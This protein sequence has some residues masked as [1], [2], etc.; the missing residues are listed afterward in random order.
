MILDAVET[1]LGFFGFDRIAFSNIIRKEE[2][3]GCGT[4]N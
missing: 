4:K 2:E 1:V 3:N